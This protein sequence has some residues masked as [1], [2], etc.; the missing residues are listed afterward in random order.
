MDINR[1]SAFKSPAL[2]GMVNPKIRLVSGNPNV[3]VWISGNRLYGKFIGNDVSEFN[4]GNI[5]GRIEKT[6]ATG[7]SLGIIDVTD[8]VK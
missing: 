4:D 7:N 8:F 3:Q 6:F 5:S 1:I 2:L